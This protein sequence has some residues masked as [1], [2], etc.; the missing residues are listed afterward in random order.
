MDHRPDIVFLDIN[1]GSRSGFDII[2][3]LPDRNFSLV[4][5]SAYEDYALEAFELE[6]IHYLLKPV[7]KEDLLNTIKRIRSRIGNTVES[8]WASISKAIEAPAR[9]KIAVPSAKGL[10]FISIDQL[11]RCEAEGAYTK[12]ILKTATPVLTTRNLGE[13]EK[14]LLPAMSFLRVHNS[15]IINLKEVVRYIRGEGGQAVMTDGVTIDISR[16]K[17]T[18]FIEWM[19][20]I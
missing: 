11:L 1:L 3:Q 2:R 8:N 13:Y 6:A 19:E 14:I 7:S 4:I 5:T 20:K 17:K 16:R 15:V 10:V 9:N 18:E 12:L